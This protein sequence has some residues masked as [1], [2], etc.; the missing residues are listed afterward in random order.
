MN[1]G[2]Q[3]V[4]D[5]I[6]AN[7]SFVI[8]THVNPEGDAIGSEVA[9]ALALTKI[10]KKVTLINKDSVP[11]FLKFLPGSDMVRVADTIVEPHDAF[12][13]VDCEP[14]RTGIKGQDSFPIKTVINID[15][16]ITNPKTADV[17]WVDAEAAAAGEMVYDLILAMDIPIDKD[18]ATNLY[19]TIFTDTGS[20]RYSNTDEPALV[21]SGKLLSYGVNTWEISENVYESK[22]YGRMKLLGLVLA[23]LE[24]GGDGMLA[25]VTVL[26]DFYRQTGTSAEDTDGFIN[27]ARAV[28]GV[29]LALL[30]REAGPDKVK[31]SFRSKGRVDVSGLASELGGGGHPNAAGVVMTGSIT[32]IKAIVIPKAEALVRETFAVKA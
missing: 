4:M 1:E 19:T 16:H 11:E 9:L 5:A 6:N 26:E 28:K 15:H 32:E 3:A 29:E 24:V 2:M 18:I 17:Y 8:S 23:G 7:G 22:S 13:V 31:M 25:W 21:K 20:F 10:G 12:L 30:F 14:A 27:Y